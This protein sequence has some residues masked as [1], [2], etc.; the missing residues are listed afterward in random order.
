MIIHTDITR[1]YG[2]II[3]RGE[4]NYLLRD[5][6]VI[7]VGCNVGMFSLWA[8]P[9]ADQIHAIDISKENID[10]LNKTIKDSKILNIETYQ[11]GISGK[12]GS[13]LI[14][15]KT[16]A[17]NGGWRLDEAG[18]EGVDAYTLGDFMD[19]NKIEHAD[20]VKLDVEGEEDKIVDTIPFDRVTTVIGEH[21]NPDTGE[22]FRSKFVGRGFRFDW[23][24]NDHFIARK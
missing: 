4:Y 19:V 17:A 15:Q 10:N 24:P 5:L 20:I 1:F 18:T 7:D 12:T 11:C 3:E 22:A 23:R 2:D 16:A 9:L 13:A 6:V 8:E 21:H 14:Q